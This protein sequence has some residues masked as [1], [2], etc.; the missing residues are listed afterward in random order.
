[1]TP[2]A[3]ASPAAAPDWNQIQD[4]LVC[5]LCE[6]NLR[7]LSEARCPECGHQVEWGD[8]L[9][10]SK[11]EHPWLFEHRRRRKIQGLIRTF[12]A[13]QLPRYFWRSVRLLH[14]PVTARLVAYWLIVTAICV[15]A[16]A[17]ARYSEV[18]KYYAKLPYARYELRLAM[19][20]EIARHK[21]LPPGT[22]LI[23]RYTEDM[24]AQYGSVAA[25]ARIHL[26]F[27]LSKADFGWIAGRTSSLMIIAN[28]IFVGC[29]LWPC[30][31]FFSLLLF[32]QTLWNAKI[33]KA[34]LFRC[35]IYSSDVG[36]T[37]AM[38]SAWLLS[39]SI[40]V[41][42]MNDHVYFPMVTLLIPAAMAAAI[43]VKLSYACSAYLGFPHAAAV[44]AASQIIVLLSLLTVAPFH[45]GS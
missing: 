43:S 27:M 25:V 26:P 1:M 21:S 18:L 45:W 34:H 37:L 10:R 44:A 2:D 32:R 13:S 17:A 35:A 36:F 42:D 22:R 39:L 19:E 11:T 33:K 14:P 4:D 24:V 12:F 28:S 38:P 23:D 6:Y 31:T 8:L 41:I 9:D 40:F 7:G 5:P 20:E 16:A 29:A 30:L 15:G 3:P